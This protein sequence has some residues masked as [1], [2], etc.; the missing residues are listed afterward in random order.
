MKLTFYIDY[1]T[2][3]GESVY[4][5]DCNSA[6]KDGSHAIKMDFDGMSTWFYTLTLPDSVKEFTYCYVVKSDI[7]QQPCRREWGKPHHVLLGKGLDCDVF[8]KWQD[9]PVDSSF[10]SSAF[11]E[12]IFAGTRSQAPI[13]GDK[14]CVLFKMNAPVVGPN[15]VLAVVGSNEMLGN[16]N[17][18]QAIIL[19]N[20]NFPEWSFCL[21]L[22]LVKYPFEYKFLI[23]KKDT[24]EVVA[25]ENRDNRTFDKLSNKIGPGL[26]VIRIPDFV[27]SRHIESFVSSCIILS[28]LL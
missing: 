14:G 19:N 24:H 12:S 13:L 16:W 18:E 1:R 8:D 10:Y 23:L 25:W 15:E 20:Y 7:G 9:E 6:D 22:S 3:W 5:I 27:I 28:S 2:N 11:T 26:T 4:L 17:P 21:D